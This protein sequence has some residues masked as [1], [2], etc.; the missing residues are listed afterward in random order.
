MVFGYFIYIRRC[1]LR[2]GSFYR[3]LHSHRQAPSGYSGGDFYFSV[4]GGSI[5]FV[6]IG[7]VP[8]TRFI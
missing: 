1:L 2:S 3:A 7:N 8:F 6:V 5:E 4:V